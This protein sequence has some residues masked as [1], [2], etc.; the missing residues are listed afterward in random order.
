M[1]VSVRAVA[2]RLVANVAIVY[3]VG[4]L[5]LAVALL[6]A[7]AVGPDKP[8]PS[9]GE[10]MVFGVSMAMLAL[11]VIIVM[12]LLLD[13]AA[14]QTR[15]AR[16]LA[17]ATCMIPAIAVAIVAINSSPS[18]VAVA[19]IGWLAVVGLVVGVVVRLPGATPSSIE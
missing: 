11:P 4:I 5:G 12:L 8:G 19:Y 7:R 16:W 10:Y 9:I 18:S 14:R 13:W 15:R 6:L 17:V 2:I 3:G 1:L